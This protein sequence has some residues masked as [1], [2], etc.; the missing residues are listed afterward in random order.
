MTWLRGAMDHQLNVPS[1]LLKEI[2][3]GS[4]IADI[5]GHMPKARKRGD[6]LRLFSN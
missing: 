1:V 2:F 5:D 3:N 4:S 6:K